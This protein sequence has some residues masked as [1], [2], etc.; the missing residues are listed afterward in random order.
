MTTCWRSCVLSSAL[1]A[2]CSGPTTSGAAPAR[3]IVTTLVDDVYL[4]TLEELA[5]QAP[6]LVTATTA[7]C[8]SPDATTLARA[9]DAWRALRVPLG[10][11]ESM[12]IGPIATLRIDAELDFWPARTSDI[13]GELALATPIDDAY[14]AGLGATR[15]GLPVIEYLLFVD[16]R[17]ETPRACA[18]LT[19]LARR[20]EDRTRVL[21][22]AWRATGGDYRGELVAADEAGSMYMS[23]GEAINAA[24]NA[25][26]V[27]VENLEGLQLAKPLGRRDGGTPQP[28]ATKSR[29]SDASAA[30]AL[31]TLAG[32][33]RVY[34][35]SL[36]EMPAP[37]SFSAYVRSRDAML[38]DEV[39][40]QLA[41]CEDTIRAW[42]A[43]LDELVVSDPE[44]PSASFECAKEL[45]ALLKADVAGLLGITPTFGDVDGD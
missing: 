15:K 25:L 27:A 24:G 19:A 2:A 31:A 8:A 12:A 38:D 22:E 10:R 32:A 11:Q 26:I 30:D 39:L 34:L 18:Y 44:P 41:R 29:F 14:V 20:V 28:G 36:T 3:E 4:P 35:G 16:G 33:R 40:A 43:P 17:L 37:A 1:L 42:P 6:A 45:L 9:R 7:L 13:D 5:A 21:V 23:L